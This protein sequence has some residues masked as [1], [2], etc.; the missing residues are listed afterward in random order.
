MGDRTQDRSPSAWAA[1]LG[2][3][4]EAG[5]RVY[6]ACTAQACGNS[7]GLDLTSLA[8]KFG[9]DFSLWDR[10]PVCPAC[11]RLGHYMASPGHGTPFRPLK[12]GIEADVRREIFLRS[13]GLTPR[14]ITRLKL[15]AERVTPT[16]DPPPLRDLDVPFTIGA[17]WPG[18]DLTS[19]G[20]FLGHWKEMTLLWWPMNPAERAVWAA[21]PKGP[22]PL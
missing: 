2:Q 20:H 19:T 14:D 3:M 13:F 18:R 8:K 21:R 17:V 11:G 1:T 4:I 16:W 10:K 7:T 5:A 22:R 15:L 9:A 12:T 6:L